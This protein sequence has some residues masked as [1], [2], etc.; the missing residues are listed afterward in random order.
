MRKCTRCGS[1]INIESHHKRP[2]YKGGNNSKKN[3]EDLCR[4]C[5]DF[6]HAEI[7]IKD[8]LKYYKKRIKLLE[9]RLNVLR[10]LNTPEEIIQKG[11]QSY[12]IDP[13]TH[14]IKR[15]K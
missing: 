15:G 3:K 10:K 1:E 4:A 12:W 5:H 8:S 14:E 11:Y 9:H 6:K 2:R 7:N 13:T